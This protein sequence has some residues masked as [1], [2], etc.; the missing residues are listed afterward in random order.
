MNV[1]GIDPGKN[2]GL[3]LLTDPPPQ[4]FP[5]VGRIFRAW[6]TPLNGKSIDWRELGKIFAMVNEMGDVKVVI[7]LM[8]AFVTYDKKRKPCILRSTED[9]LRMSGG[10]N[11][12]IEQAGLTPLTVYSISWKTY[13]RKR[14]GAPP[15]LKKHAEESG[16]ER[17]V[18]GNRRNKAE[19]TEFSNRMWKDASQ[20]FGRDWTEGTQEA[21]LI[22]Q[23]YRDTVGAVKGG[24]R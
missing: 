18:R 10:Y 9:L 20:E 5:Q 17:V 22:G 6:R 13:W 2:G 21:A 24:T 7:E 3:V 8:Q 14:L 12:L 15:R 1:L 19:S 16:A 4:Q 23:Y 11:L